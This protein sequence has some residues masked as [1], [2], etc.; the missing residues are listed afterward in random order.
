M[1]VA[2]PRLRC[3]IAPH[4]MASRISLVAHGHRAVITEQAPIACG[5]RG[6]ESRIVHTLD[7]QLWPRRL[8]GIFA[9]QP[10][11]SGTVPCTHLA[12]LGKSHGM[13]GLRSA[14]QRGCM[15]LPHCVQDA[16]MHGFFTAL[17]ARAQSSSLYQRSVR[18]LPQAYADVCIRIPPVVACVGH[19]GSCASHTPSA[20]GDAAAVCVVRV[21]CAYC[22]CCGCPGLGRQ[23]RLT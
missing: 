19:M 20:R 23:Q 2:H 7:A 14:C 18:T 15:V 13:P 11:C 5:K 22:G 12:G 17:R 10:H 1:R 16:G 9:G 3:C 21:H 4:W 6:S 8:M